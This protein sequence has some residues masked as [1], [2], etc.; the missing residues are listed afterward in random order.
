MLTRYFESMYQF[1]IRVEIY[2]GY[3]QVHLLQSC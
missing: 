1:D 3:W 2:E